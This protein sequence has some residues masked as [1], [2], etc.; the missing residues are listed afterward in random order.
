MCIRDSFYRENIITDVTRLVKGGK[1]ANVYTC[2][3]HPATGLD[4]VAAKL[5]RERMLRSL[6]NDAIYK[7]GRM[8]R[9]AE[10]KQI[11]SRRER[12]AVQNKS[13]Y[14]LHLDFMMWIGT[15]YRTQTLLHDAGADVP[16]PVA[17]RARSIDS[18]LAVQKS[19]RPAK[20][21]ARVPPSTD[22]SSPPSGTP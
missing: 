17:H 20:A 13:G 2:T 6:K 9:D 1:E 16:K 4:L 21:C 3:A 10:G 12:T 19:R 7:E 5:Y 15:E 22:S 11:R 18:L 8:L 14:G